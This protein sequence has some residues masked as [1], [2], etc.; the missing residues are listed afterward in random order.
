MTA[1]VV[2]AV[3]RCCANT[4]N[5]TTLGGIMITEAAAPAKKKAVRGEGTSITVDLSEYPELVYSIISAADIDDRSRAV[6]LRR[7]LV[8]LA[9]DGKLFEDGE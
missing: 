1:Y 8:K 3:G 4:S 6:W 2:V 5:T 9:D 7:R